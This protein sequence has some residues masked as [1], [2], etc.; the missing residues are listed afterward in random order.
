MNARII[1]IALILLS[2][3]ITLDQ[4]I[5]FDGWEWHQMYTLWHHEGVALATFLLGVATL[6]RSRR[7][8]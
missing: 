7:R 5:R 3:A 2:I 6:L 1:G 4:L 8:A